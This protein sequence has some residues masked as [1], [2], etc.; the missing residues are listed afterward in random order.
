MAVSGR[1]STNTGVAPAWLTDSAVAMNVLTGT[2][3]S[4][5][6]PTPTAC[7]ARRRASVPELTPAQ[8]RVAAELGEGGLEGRALGPQR[9]GGPRGDRLE[10]REELVVQRARLGAQIDEGYLHR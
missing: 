4:S 2:M 9:V 5:P 6:G 3:T 7:R 10:D 8:N 1:Q